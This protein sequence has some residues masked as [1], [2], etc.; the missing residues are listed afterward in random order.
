MNKRI[1]IAPEVF[2]EHMQP[3]YINGD[4]LK[5]QPETVYRIDRKGH[6]YYYTISED[7]EPTFYIS[8]TTFIKQSLPTS[9][10]L[11]K[12]MIENG[13]E[14]KDIAEERALYGTFLHIQAGE[15]LQNASYD[16]D[17]LVGKLE[18]Y[19][20][21]H[22]LPYSFR[23]NADELKRDV[24]AFAQ[25]VIEKNVVPIAIEIL[26]TDKERGLAGAIDL[27]CEMDV[28]VKVLTNEVFKSGPRKGQ[29]KEGKE[30][31]RKVAIVDLKSGRKG[32]FESAEIQLHQYKR[33]WEVN[34][35]DIKIDD[36]FNWS[37]KAW[38]GA[39]PT[40]NLKSQ[41]KAKSAKKLDHLVAIAQIED[42]GKNNSL[43]IC[44]GVITIAD[45]LYNNIE[46][47]ELAELVKKRH[48]PLDMNDTKDK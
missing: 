23:S 13:D 29:K 7:G 42:S 33:M 38:T 22:H 2:D 8:V 31:Q 3:E 37:P 16:L 35:P 45:G 17:S 26:L 48:E 32:F 41:I 43:T 24:L 34:F 9:P 4:W 25:F 27:V 47:M 30:I 40:Y 28:E 20:E 39:T 15:L 18:L 36:I 11:I 21:K 46:Y 14:S 1:E 10:Y 5:Q 44:H 12:W 6:R 19:M